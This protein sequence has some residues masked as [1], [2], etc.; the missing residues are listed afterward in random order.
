MS[1]GKNFEIV[2]LNVKFAVFAPV[3]P[4][5]TDTVNKSTMLKF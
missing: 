4:S 1:Q 3:I 2:K 5:C